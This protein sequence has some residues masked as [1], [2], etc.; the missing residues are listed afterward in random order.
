MEHLIDT[1]TESVTISAFSPFSTPYLFDI[2][3][4]VAA[5]HQ[6]FRS[7]H[8]CEVA[9]KMGSINKVVIGFLIALIFLM[10]G[11]I[12]YTIIE[13]YSTLDALYMTVIT[14]S[15][16]GFGEIHTLSEAGRLFT[17]FLI[18]FGFGSLGFLAHA[19]TEAIVEKATS[20]NLVKRT[21]QK[22]IQQLNHHVIICGY[23]RVGEATAEY[24][25]SVGQDFVIIESST[26]K[27]K[28]LEAMGYVFLEGDATREHM[29][30]AAGIKRASALLA[31]LDS[32][33]ENLFTVLTARE[34]N[35]TLQIIAR[36]EVATSES[37]MLRAGAD[38]IISPH[39]T[40]GRS[41]A[42]KVMSVHAEIPAPPKTDIEERK[43]HWIPVDEQA[44]LASHVV[45]TAEEFLHTR[46]IGIRRD[47]V[48][49]L[50]PAP[51]EQLAL[52]DELLVSS[53]EMESLLAAGRPE[54]KK[55]VLIDDN[56]VIR[57]LYTRLFQ[58]AGFH[59]L[60]AATG[61]EGYN[62]LV[63]EK[64]DAGIIDYEL[65][66]MSGLDICKRVRQETEF[67]N[68]RLF[69]FTAHDDPETRQEA[70]A[71]GVD[72]IVIKSPD[73]S[74]I[75]NTVKQKFKDEP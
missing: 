1:E 6:P 74:E 28:E 13:D 67:D 59:L 23:G 2:H 42:A 31:L 24:F 29:L 50:M 43:P 34:L 32:D 7:P 36:T 14:I 33:P 12:G 57:R 70:N 62:L 66:D 58:K 47:S 71:A 73:A 52:G 39:A 72:T 3:H 27:V 69:L 15:T 30:Q 10:I 55:I 5:N 44:D 45:E 4:K 18:M 25:N 38:S 37:R 54:V 9:V 46:I 11:T 16:V 48:D 8:S 56:P 17:I 61:S 26:D 20:Q 19:F 65:P 49:I 22:K 41:V 75:V 21:M 40:A 51:D 63:A 68:T 60:T 53:W 35:P 64:P